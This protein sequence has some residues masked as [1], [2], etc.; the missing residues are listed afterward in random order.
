MCILC[1]LLNEKKIRQNFKGK[2]GYWLYTYISEINIDYNTYPSDFW[3]EI[4]DIN[5]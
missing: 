3:A 5:I 4:Q 2:T 1:I